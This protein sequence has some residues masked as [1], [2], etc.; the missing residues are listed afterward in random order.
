MTSW[1]RLRFPGLVVI[2]EVGSLPSDDEELDGAIKPFDIQWNSSL[3]CLQIWVY[4]IYLIFL[5][6]ERLSENFRE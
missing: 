4:S 1:G 5:L 6:C 2:H 3:Y